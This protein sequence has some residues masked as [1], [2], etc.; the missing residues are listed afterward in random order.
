MTTERDAILTQF[1]AAL[2][3]IAPEADVASLD[4][5]RELRDQLDLDSFDVLR[6]LVSL[7]KRLGVDVPE[8]E[9]RRMRTL[10]EAIARLAELLERK[11]PTR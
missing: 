9:A 5:R 4:P 2:S 6:L 8:A 10:D 7:K 3:E 1:L 11:P